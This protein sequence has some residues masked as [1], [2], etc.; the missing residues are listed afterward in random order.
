LLINFL[1]TGAK[2]NIEIPTKT[3]AIAQVL[4]QTNR[5]LGLNPKLI[6]TITNVTKNVVIKLI[7]IAN[8]IS[9]FVFNMDYFDF[10]SAILKQRNAEMNVN[11]VKI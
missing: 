8:L 6:E 11:G 4:I 3:N 1:K 10:S 2:Y 7:K 5:K 9:S